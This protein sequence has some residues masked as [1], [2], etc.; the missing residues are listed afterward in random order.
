MHNICKVNI[1]RF[2]VRIKYDINITYNCVALFVHNRNR[3]A[4]LISELIPNWESHR[5]FFV[6]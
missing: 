2:E 4:C 3:T 1:I 5:N 6:H